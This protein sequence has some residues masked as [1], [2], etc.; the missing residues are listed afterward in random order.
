MIIQ[1]LKDIL[2]II[3]SMA[4]RIPLVFLLYLSSSGLELIGLSL[5]VP[6]VTAI[7]Y[8]EKLSDIAAFSFIQQFMNFESTKEIIIFLSLSILIVFGV[9]TSLNVL[10]QR[11]IIIFSYDLQVE[12]RKRLAKAYLRAPYIFHTSKRSS[13]I[14]NVIQGHVSQFSKGVVGSL[15]R[16]TGEIVIVSV[17]GIFLLISYP[18]TSLIAASV[19]ISFIIVYTFVIKG[20]MRFL[21]TENVVAN[22]NMIKSIS[23]GI[24]GLKEARVFGNI[25]YFEKAIIDSA[26][27]ASE[28]NSKIAF[29]QILPRYILEFIIICVV[30]LTIVINI[31]IDNSASET[32]SSIAV[33]AVAALRLLPSA[34]QISSNLNTLYYTAPM[35]EEIVDDIKATGDGKIKPKE[36]QDLELKRLD[37]NNLSF[38]YPNSDK[39]ILDSINFSI[40]K[41]EVIGLFGESGSGKSTLAN[42]ILGLLNFQSGN[43]S[44]NGKEISNNEWRKFNFA[45]Y[46]PQT[47]TMI[48]DTVMANVA[49]GQEQDDIDLNKI[50]TALKKAHLDTLIDSLPGGIQTTTG[51]DALYFSGGQKQ[52]LAISRS[53]YFKRSLI[54]LDE[55][56]SA[57]DV[58]TEKDVLSA[59]KE[60]REDAAIIIIS[61]STQAES[62]CDRVYNIKNGKLIEK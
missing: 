16:I 60:L 23:Q 61:H 38:C 49:L 54:I 28:V 37:F 14:I 34:S 51:E 55:V 39:I 22:N 42:I 62:I 43:V 57:L 17:I 12:L 25:K 1:K 2:F 33:F 19:I 58:E 9:K 18:I 30:V 53:F 56:T 48:D 45:S 47:P 36:Q 41:G 26:F 7:Q 21:G 32:I 6:F 3:G 31:A 52:R 35:M 8:P 44:L 5:I 27:K 59:I 29:F 50:N 24:K 4:S 15:L 13:E 20:K 46:I 11:S 10:I 40:Q